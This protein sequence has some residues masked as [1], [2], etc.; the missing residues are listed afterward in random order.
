MGMDVIIWVEARL[1]V[2]EARD[3]MGECAVWPALTRENAR[4]VD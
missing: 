2:F 3:I 1:A 4:K